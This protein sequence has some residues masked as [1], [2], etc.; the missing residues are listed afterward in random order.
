MKMTENILNIKDFKKST[1]EVNAPI[2]IYGAGELG[3]VV[4]KALNIINLRA[5][6]FVDKKQ[7][8]K[9]VNGMS[10]IAPELLKIYKDAYVL[11]ASSSFY[12]DM[13]EHLKILGHKKYYNVLSLIGNPELSL[14]KSPQEVFDHEYMINTY[15]YE[16][17]YKHSSQQP[18]L[19]SLDVVITEKCT[20]RCASCAN[21]M[22]YYSNYEADDLDVV[23]S[24]VDRFLECVD[25][26]SRMY[27]IGGEPFMN[28]KL[29]RIIN[30]YKD[31]PKVGIIWI[32]TNGT[33]VPDRVNLD[34]MKSNKV[35]VRLTDYGVLAK[36]FDKFKECMELENIPY[37]VFSLGCWEDLGAMQ[38]RGYSIEKKKRIYE[39]CDCRDD[40]FTLLRGKLY[41]CP[42]SAHGDYLGA[43]PRLEGDCINLTDST[44]SNDQIVTQLDYLKN[45][46]EYI[47]A[48]GFC[49]GRGKMSD[50]VEPAIQ[51][52]RPLTLKKYNR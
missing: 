24:S 51:A 30:K 7:A 5:D 37:K 29:Y 26:L 40:L 12:D 17:I 35:G 41:H 44:L 45:R 8:G 14:G 25:Y 15:S 6:F 33:I 27:V 9:Q 42:W 2:I 38:D 49:S 28:K 13:V 20:L 43:I 47:S 39:L 50:S 36:K 46:C 16:S 32:Y 11:I 21:A 1:Y 3:R 23:I 48:C 19:L 22:Q 31:H 4:L 34:A 18:H 52:K 10:V